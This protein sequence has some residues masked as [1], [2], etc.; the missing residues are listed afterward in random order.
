MKTIETTMKWNREKLVN[1]VGDTAED[2]KILIMLSN[3]DLFNEA[4][5]RGYLNGENPFPYTKQLE[6]TKF[7]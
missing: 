3:Y 6:I 2:K 1:L 7:I 5:K 4:K